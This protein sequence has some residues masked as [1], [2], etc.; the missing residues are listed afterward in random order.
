MGVIVFDYF[1]NRLK[2]EFVSNIQEF[3]FLCSLIEYK[4]I[5]F[6]FYIVQIWLRSNIV[7]NMVAFK[8]FSKYCSKY[9][10]KYYPKTINM[11]T[12]RAKLSS[13]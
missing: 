13:R 2:L 8:Y 4:E 1:S 10:S 3:L 9:R 5:P 7:L 12:L 6:K 11:D